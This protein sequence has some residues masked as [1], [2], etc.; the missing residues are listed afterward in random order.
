MVDGA[1]GPGMSLIPT[2]RAV[3]GGRARHREEAPLPDSR[4]MGKPRPP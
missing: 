3:M 4:Q 1:G 2:L